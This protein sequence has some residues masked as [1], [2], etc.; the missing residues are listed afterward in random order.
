MAT[1]PLR[2]KAPHPTD[3]HEPHLPHEDRSTQAIGVAVTLALAA[4]VILGTLAL[5]A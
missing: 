1:W 3:T 4:V 2:R 5:F